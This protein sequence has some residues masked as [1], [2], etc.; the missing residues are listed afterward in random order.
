MFQCKERDAADVP[1]LPDTNTGKNG[2]TAAPFLI[3]AGNAI[4]W[5]IALDA[6]NNMYVAG[7]FFGTAGFGDS[8]AAAA[9]S[10]DAF[11][12]KYNA[13]GTL[14]WIRS[15]G[16]SGYDEA[17]GVAIDPEGNVLVTGDYYGT[18]S[19][20][21]HTVKSTG[22]ADVFIARFSTN[23][24]AQWLQSAGSTGGERG[25]DLAV[26]GAGNVYVTGEFQG[27]AHFGQVSRQSAGEFDVFIAK[28]SRNGALQWAESAG[29]GQRET[30]YGIIADRRTG[31]LYVTGA[32]FGTT[33]F[34]STTTTSAGDADVFFAKYNTH[35]AL[36]WMRS[37][38][39]SGDDTGRDLALD[40]SG[41]VFLTG[42]AGGETKGFLTKYDA[43]GNSLWG[44]SLRFDSEGMGVTTDDQ[45]NAYVISSGSAISK[46]SADGMLL[47]AQIP[48]SSDLVTGSG[49][50]A[51]KSGKLYIT[52]FYKGTITF[53]QA[54]KAAAGVMDMYVL[55]GDL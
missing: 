12:A 16:G 49:I 55:G 50:T 23:G 37:A 5:D 1:P 8:T 24:E 45:G 47:R 21:A 52:G 31:D 32:Y 44:Q 48:R 39:G 36:Q 26:D 9:G 18:I 29:G 54:S 10:Y 2:D 30:G 25:H 34:G 41:H 35:G 46:Y 19:I 40:P 33:A 17:R 43:D 27:T 53:G 11:V 20:G 7:S 3:T 6:E 15:W 38:G 42:Q 51:G 28:Y 4:G 13:N 14:Q 22:D